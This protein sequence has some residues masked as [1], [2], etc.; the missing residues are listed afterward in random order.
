MSVSQIFSQFCNNLKVDNKDTISYR[1]KQITKRLNQD[2]WGTESDVDHSLYGGSYG[3]GTAIN[4][5]SD[6][7]MYFVLP[8]KYYV[9]Y[10]NYQ[11]NGQS[12]L[13]QAVKNSISKTYSTTKLRGDGQV[14]IV[15]FSDG[16]IFEVVPVFINKDGVTYTY[17]D[18]NNGGSWKVTK[19]KMEID[20]INEMNKKC[21]GNLK[22]L[23]KMVRAWRNNVNLKMGG[24]LIDTL[25]YNFIMNWEYKDKSY[26]YYDWLS[27]DFF[28]Y[29]SNQ[30][31]DQ[32]YWLAPGSNQYVWKKE[33]FIY[34]AKQAYNIAKE[35]CECHSNNKDEDAKELW[36]E[37][38]GSKF[39]N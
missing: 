19:F 2:F 26:T 9:Q 11:G 16:V 28:K 23:C 38:Y 27:R 33:N 3:R 21:N 36:R 32:E 5:V 30:N 25:C 20:A 13:L 12:A 24:L 29:L 1:Y 10:S 17:P 4:F 15:E 35:A 18:A 39:P 6:I 37:I 22:E 8:Y 7:D 14:V 31:P 34:K